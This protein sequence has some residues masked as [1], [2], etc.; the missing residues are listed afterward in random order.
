MRFKWKINTCHFNFKIK[1]LI[2]VALQLYSAVS[3]VITQVLTETT[4]MKRHLC[5]WYQS[6]CMWL[7]SNATD[8]TGSLW[9]GMETWKWVCRPSL[10][11]VQFNGTSTW[12]RRLFF[13][14]SGRESARAVR[15]AGNSAKYVS[16]K[17]PFV[18]VFINFITVLDVPLLHDTI[19]HKLYCI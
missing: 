10:S 12:E 16:F 13:R 14:L 3:V 19:I 2:N 1:A 11:Y 4:F 5:S 8:L 7:A 6:S 15:T 9:K 17:C 18:C